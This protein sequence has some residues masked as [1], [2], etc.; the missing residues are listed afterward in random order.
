MSYMEYSNELYR[1][2]ASNLG[3]EYM[4]IQP[5]GYNLKITSVGGSGGKFRPSGFFEIRNSYKI[6]SQKGFIFYPMVSLNYGMTIYYN[7]E[8]KIDAGV[9]KAELVGGI[10]FQRPF[11]DLYSISAEFELF[12]E[13]SKFKIN[14][15]KQDSVYWGWRTE[16][17]N[18]FKI[19]LPIAVNISE[20]KRLEITPFYSETFD[21][22][23]YT[24]GA[25]VAFNF[26]I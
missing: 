1:G 5:L 9:E 18:G 15:Q 25:K 22:G 13:I 3:I 17:N 24:R 6:D 21:K 2:S 10:G 20:N 8:S 4:Y 23:Y 7:K 26:Q 12:Q 14:R 19:S 16:K 11:G